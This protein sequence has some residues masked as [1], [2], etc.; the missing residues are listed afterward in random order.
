MVAYNH[1]SLFRIYIKKLTG[2]S[3]AYMMSSLESV[4]DMKQA[5]YQS[6]R[7]PSGQQ[8]L[9]Y[10]GRQLVGECSLPYT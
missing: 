4:A 7:I 9:I 1:V 10:S 6:L 8:R 5:I 2:K 3:F